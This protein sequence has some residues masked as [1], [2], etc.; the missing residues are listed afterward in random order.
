[1][2]EIAASLLATLLRMSLFLGAAALAVQLLL[3]FARPGSSRVHRVAWFL[4]LLQGWFWWRLPVTIPCYEPAVVTEAMLR[5]ADDTESRCHSRAPAP[6]QL[7]PSQIAETRHHAAV[8]HPHLFL[9]YPI[10]RMPRLTLRGPLTAR[11]PESWIATVRRN[12]PVAILGGWAAGMLIL[13]GASIVGYLRFLRCLRAT[14]ACG[15]GLGA[16]M[17][18][19]AR[20]ASRPHGRAALGHGQRWPAALPHA[21]GLS[22]GGAGR[23]VAAARA[24]RP[25]EH[26]AARTGASPAARSAEVD[27]RPPADAAALVQ[28]AGMAGR[29]PLRRGGGMGLRR[30]RQGSRF[31]GMPRL[32]RGAAPIG[33][34]LR[35]ASVVS[36]RRLGPRPFRSRSTF[37]QS[38]SQGRLDHE[39]DHDSRSR[40]GPGI[41]LP[42][43]FGSC[44]QGAGRKGPREESAANP[45]GHGKTARRA[46]RKNR[47]PPA[48]ADA[49][50]YMPNG[51][52]GFSGPT[53]PNCARP[54]QPG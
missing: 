15:R 46:S 1:M 5:S 47:K 11:Q 30:S 39:E 13:A 44:R 20:A 49:L 48:S 28:S 26:L 12:W 19:F 23:A 33:R 38:P 24:G 45:A 4:V 35:A 54:T 42:G 32:C 27:P 8:R 6:R 9:R 37:T 3:K 10:V 16:G 31:G 21:A 34:R 50:R 17:G 29:A 25:A 43:P 14:H 2:N 52:Q 53:W 41:A 22:V 7:A 40:V 18:R 51:C 36:R